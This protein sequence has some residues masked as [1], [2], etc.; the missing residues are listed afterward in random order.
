MTKKTN[1][2]TSLSSE[3]SHI[4]S[5]GKVKMVDVTDKP[6][7]TREAIAK[8]RI[9]IT[10]AALKII[11]SGKTAKGNP[12]QTARLAGIMAA[13]RTAELIPLCHQLLLTYVDL[14]IHS[15]HLGYEI[16]A[17]VRTKSETGVE[18]E[19]LTAVTVAS[20][21]IYDMVK[22]ID[23]DMEIG[24]IRLVEKR[25]GSSGDYKKSGE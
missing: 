15:D 1:R 16:E 2:E 19:A 17:C 12:L 9:N 5:T 23:R 14:K 24:Q 18:M 13:K 20:L 25:G 11:R 6:V 4:D 7:S 3:L 22:A 8:G 21:T 10:P